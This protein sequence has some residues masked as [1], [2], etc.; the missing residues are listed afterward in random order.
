MTTCLSRCLDLVRSM[1][2]S[3]AYETVRIKSLRIGTLDHGW[4]KPHASGDISRLRLDQFESGIL[5]SALLLVLRE[6]WCTI[7]SFKCVGSP[8]QDPTLILDL[9]DEQQRF[10][11]QSRSNSHPPHKPTL[12]TTTLSNA[13]GASH[14]DR[15]LHRLAFGPLA[16]ETL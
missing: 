7:T 4:N 16:A 5:M 9:F 14:A 13:H 2:F 3:F 6:S 8:S 12:A 15:P 11:R 10:R 1:S